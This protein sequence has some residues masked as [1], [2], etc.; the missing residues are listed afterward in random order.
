M[1]A[2]ARPEPIVLE[3]TGADEERLLVLNDC[4]FC[5]RLMLL[6]GH[7]VKSC[8]NVMELLSDIL[9]GYKLSLFCAFGITEEVRSMP[10]WRISGSSP[11]LWPSHA[12][13]QGLM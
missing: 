8:F 11:K 5:N 6:D 12:K 9:L 13:R 4:T 1:G 2:F 7:P 10:L 3:L